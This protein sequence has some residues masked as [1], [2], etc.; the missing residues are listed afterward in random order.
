[1]EETRKV[2]WSWLPAAMPGVAAMVRERRR[3]FGDAHVN[4]CWQRGVVEGVP[5]WFFAREGAVAV[6]TPT[7]LCDELDAVG[8]AAGSNRAP[9]LL[10]HEPE[11][12]NGAY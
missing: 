11:G 2:D 8:R 7:A 5:G 4:L 1:M 12:L 3:Q 10:M 9:L 6:G